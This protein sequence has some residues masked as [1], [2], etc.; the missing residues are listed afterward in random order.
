MSTHQWLDRKA[1]EVAPD[2]DLLFL[3]YVL[4]EKTPLMDP[5]ARGTLVG[6]GLHHDLR[7]IWRAALEGVVFGF[8]NHVDVFGECGLSVAQVFAADGGAA[9]DLWLQIAAD[10]LERPVYRIDRHPGSCLGAAYV[11]AIGTGALAD[12]SGIGRYV[13]RG[14]CFEPQA[15]AARALDVKYA[16]WRD[17]YRRL[18]DL[19]P[20]LGKS[21]K[22]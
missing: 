6:L 12:W 2:N 8:R 14:R 10:A 7:H 22:S 21:P 3:P 11:A 16:L 19:Y 17:T 20:Q 13:A 4:G 1:A 5:H 15:G 18:R 9:S